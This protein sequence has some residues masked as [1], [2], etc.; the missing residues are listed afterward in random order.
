M[1]AQLPDQD[2]V[3]DLHVLWILHGEDAF[4]QRDVF[5]LSKIHTNWHKKRNDKTNPKMWPP[6]FLGGGGEGTI[7][8][9]SLEFFGAPP[10]KKKKTENQHLFSLSL[11]CC[12]AFQLPPQLRMQL[13][14][15]RHGSIKPRLV[16]TV[17]VLR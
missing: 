10:P 11:Q 3:C 12:R 13:R 2:I 4:H 15:Q 9:Q 14:Y 1:F 8:K 6:F 7:Y 17:G 5:F 16:G